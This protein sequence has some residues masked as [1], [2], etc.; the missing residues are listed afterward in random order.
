LQTI[1]DLFPE[2]EITGMLYDTNTGWVLKYDE[3]KGLSSLENFNKTY[4]WIIQKKIQQLN[5][6]LEESKKEFKDLS[7]NEINEE[8]ILKEEKDSISA[9]EDNIIKVE[10][11]EFQTFLKKKSNRIQLKIPTFQIPKIYFPKLKVH[12]PKYIKYRDD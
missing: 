2:I 10:N 1:Q 8:V 5:K 6:F 4:E 11:Y 7:E 12:L 9:E 3:F